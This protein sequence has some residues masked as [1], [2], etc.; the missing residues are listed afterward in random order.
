MTAASS[1]KRNSLKHMKQGFVLAFRCE[2]L[3]SFPSDMVHRYEVYTFCYFTK[4][5]LQNFGNDE[6]ILERWLSTTNHF[7]CPTT[8]L[9][10]FNPSHSHGYDVG[11]M[12]EIDLNA[13]GRFHVGLKK[14][15]V[16]MPVEYIHRDT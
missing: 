1:A 12:S 3:N 8:P 13:K 4:R 2:T 7:P 10:H 11:L 6:M 16:A 15:S 5:M 9:T 14:E